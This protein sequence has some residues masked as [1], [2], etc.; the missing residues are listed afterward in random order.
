MLITWTSSVSSNCSHNMTK[1]GRHWLNRRKKEYKNGQISRSNRGYQD[2]Q[3]DR[4]L[5]AW[6]L[7]SSIVQVRKYKSWFNDKYEKQ[8][9]NAISWLHSVK[10]QWM[11]HVYKPLR[12]HNI[13]YFQ[14]KWQSIDVTTI[15]IMRKL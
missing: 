11:Q 3:Q 1:E 9:L 15:S 2:P 13:I 5:H 12:K 7:T 10:V 6:Q 14:Q 4:Q 8:K